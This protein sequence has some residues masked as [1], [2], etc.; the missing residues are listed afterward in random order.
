NQGLRKEDFK[1]EFPESTVVSY[2]GLGKAYVAGLAGDPALEPKPLLGKPL[3]KFESAGLSNEEMQNKLV[4][5]C[6]WDMEQRPSRNCVLELNKNAGKLKDK[7]IVFVII[8][9]ANIEQRK[10]DEWLKEN[11]I[12]LPTGKVETDEVK[13]LFNWGVKALPWLILTDQEHVVLDEG[14]AVSELGEK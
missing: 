13:T 1:F 6:F 4:L 5:V 3:P 10:L 9:V 2:I 12:V 14:F 11:N 7:N 8:H